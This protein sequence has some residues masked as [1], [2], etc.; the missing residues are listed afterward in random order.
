MPAATVTDWL[1]A[2]EATAL[3]TALRESTLAYP[4][5]NA[6]H[7]LGIALL[8]GGIL[9]LDL[10]LLGLWRSL[11]LQPLLRVLA[12]T[13]TAGLVLAMGC[14]LLLFI[15]RASDYVQSSLFL[16]KMV[17]VL[18]G[19]VNAARLRWLLSTERGLPTSVG[20]L[21]GSVQL[22]ALVSLLAWLSALLLGRLVGYF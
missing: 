10:R 2:L 4:L 9:P 17:V 19:V 20:T 6:G 1:L 12:S 8:V 16:S 21:P 18:A 3:A 13:A 14:G 22:G 11:P 7:I 15:G 5:V